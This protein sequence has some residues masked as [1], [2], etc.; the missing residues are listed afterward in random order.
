MNI[1]TAQAKEI[2]LELA[3]LK[4]AKAALDGNRSLSVKAAV[5]ALAPTL[6]RI[7]AICNALLP[8]ATN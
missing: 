6:E 8:V 5:F 2:R 4:P 3:K 1:T 7:I